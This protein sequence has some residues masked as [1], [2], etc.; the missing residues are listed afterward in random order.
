MTQ[1]MFEPHNCINSVFDDY[2]LKPKGT[3]V[4]CRCGKLWSLV[5]RQYGTTYWKAVPWYKSWKYKNP[6][7]TPA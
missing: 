3:I 5:R 2:S 1:L 6:K 7:E 4:R